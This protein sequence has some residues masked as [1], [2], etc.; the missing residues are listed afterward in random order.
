MHVNR[1]LSNL[2]PTIMVKTCK[3]K[4][5]KCGGKRTKHK[6]NTYKWL[7]VTRAVSVV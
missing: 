3:Q 1:S 5:F 7:I 2:F 4:L 6:Y